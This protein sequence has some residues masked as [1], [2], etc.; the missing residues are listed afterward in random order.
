MSLLSSLPKESPLPKMMLRKTALTS[1][2]NLIAPHLKGTPL[3]EERMPPPRKPK[4]PRVYK[5]PPPKNLQTRSFLQSPSTSLLVSNNSVPLPIPS[6]DFSSSSLTSSSP[7]LA[8]SDVHS[9]SND[10]CSYSATPTPFTSSSSNSHLAQSTNHF[11]SAPCTLSAPINVDDSLTYIL[12]SFDNSI[13]PQKNHPPNSSL[14]DIALPRSLYR[15]E[16]HAEAL[17]LL[18]STRV[19]SSIVEHLILITH[20]ACAKCGLILA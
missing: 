13:S 19:E 16:F 9:L 8:L 17:K 3:D 15:K 2:K 20:E 18:Y 11:S 14:S 7:P 6:I 10:H 4:K 5:R 12:D 1:H